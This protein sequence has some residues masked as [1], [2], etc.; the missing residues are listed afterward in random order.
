MLTVHSLCWLCQMPLAIAHWGICSRCSASLIHPQPLCPQCGLPATTSAFPCGRCIQKP[1][2]W[3]RL[4]TVNAYQPPLSRLI[5]RLK[6]TRH[7]ELAPALARLLLLRIRHSQGLVR[8]DRLISVPLWQ[9]RQWWRG[10]NQ[11][12]ELCRPLA[13]WRHCAWHSTA[14]RRRHATCPQHKLSAHQRKQNLK[15]AFE[16]TISVQNQHIAV[17]D[18]VVTTGST[19]AEIC[20]LLLQNGALSVQVWCLCRTL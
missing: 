7:P 14:L 20:R 10:F 17:V 2:P 11:S 9:R 18:D 8:P 15:H 4:I 19:V 6:F 12:D 5:H 13:H 1:P 16:L 3:Q